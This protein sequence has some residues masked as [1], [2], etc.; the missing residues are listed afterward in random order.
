MTARFELP[1]PLELPGY[2][3]LEKV[4]EGASGVVFKAHQEG[5]DRTVAVKVLSISG[6]SG[7]DARLQ[8]FQREA[9]LMARVAHPHVVTVYD[10]G[11][12]E[13]RA[14]LVT[15]YLEGG[16]LRSLM[17]PGRPMPLESFRRILEPVVSALSALHQQGI[18]HRDLKPENVFLAEQN[19]PKV[20]DFGIAVLRQEAGSLTRQGEGFGTIGYVA[21]EQQ[22][23]LHVDER[24]DQYSLAALA[25]E[26]L[27]GGS[28]PL[29]VIRNPSECNAGLN[30]DIDRVLMRA[31]REHPEERFDSITEFG[32]ALDAALDE[33]RKHTLSQ[34]WRVSVAVVVILI[35]LLA[36]VGLWQSDWFGPNRIDAIGGPA[37]D[38]SRSAGREERFVNSIGMEMVL[39]P[40]GEIRMES[41]GDDLERADRMVQVQRPFY[42]G[43]CEVTVDQFRTFV[44]ATGYRTVAELDGGGF[45]F[46]EQTGEMRQCP[47]ITW[48]NP[49]VWNEQRGD[50][51]VVQVSWEDAHAFCLWLS[52][53]EQ[54]EYRLPNEAEWEFACRAGRSVTS[55]PDDVASQLDASTWYAANSDFALHPVRSKLPNAFGLYHMLGNVQEWCADAR[56]P[57]QATPD[58]RPFRPVRGGAFDT[59]AENTH[60]G[61]SQISYPSYRCR[62]YGFRVVSSCRELSDASGSQPGFQ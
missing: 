29:G 20:G 18:V 21:P 5:L 14:Y 9:R 43:A 11:L 40:A 32:A 60:C 28:P 50:H 56:W 61:V 49:G 48:R 58:N 13:G 2:Q 23:G 15:E 10:A 30:V 25:Y 36:A 47:E 12:S 26:A 42:M 31:L 54:R 17:T 1:S 55:F 62:T 3:F 51:P 33:R 24:A 41:C 52:R 16:N 19:H 8:R 46:D 57:E 22:Y 27:T 37:E 7:L 59:D 4:G 38:G 35:L 6:D 34:P 45:T 39:I 44:E 53:Q